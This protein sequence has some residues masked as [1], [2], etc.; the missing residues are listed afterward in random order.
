[1]KRAT[2]VRAAGTWDPGIASD[3]VSLDAADRQ[4]RRMVVTTQRGARVLL[5]LAQ[6][7]TLHDGD[8]LSLD[9]G[10]IIAVAGR[11]E[12]LLEIIPKTRLDF[13]RLAWHLGN[14]HTDVQIGGGRLR[15]RR[16]HV[17]ADLARGTGAAVVPVEAAFDPLTVPR[18][19]DAHGA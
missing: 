8:G 18:H 9:D 19:H 4:R 17:L 16:D 11:A 1:M 14:R 6:V 10:T 7:T 3:H 12:P 15:I 13:V 5:D 2:A